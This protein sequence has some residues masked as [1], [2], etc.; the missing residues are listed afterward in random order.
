MDSETIANAMR[1]LSTILA[2]LL[3]PETL[4]KLIYGWGSGIHPA[5]EHI[6]MEVRADSLVQFVADSIRQEI[7]IPGD[8]DFT[9]KVPKGRVTFTFCHDGHL[10][11]TGNDYQLET[12]IWMSEVLRSLPL[13]SECNGAGLIAMKKAEQNTPPTP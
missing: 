4:L 12:E 10:H 11:S 1:A 8:S 9:L 5:L 2:E 3:P 6:P 7:I 13:H